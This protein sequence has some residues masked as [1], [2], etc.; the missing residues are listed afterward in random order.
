M[1]V[2]KVRSFSC[3]EQAMCDVRDQ[4]LDGFLEEIRDYAFVRSG[5]K[6]MMD[7]WALSKA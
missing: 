6:R 4:M 3:L 5:I 1:H 2:Y 7:G